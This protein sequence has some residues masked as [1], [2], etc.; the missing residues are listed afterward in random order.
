MRT[1]KI[2][3]KANTN[4]NNISKLSG[5]LE[6]FKEALFEKEFEEKIDIKTLKRVV[7]AFVKY[8]KFSS[9]GTYEEFIE[10]REK[11]FQKA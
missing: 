11:I 3:E 7:S 8:N 9:V 4:L 5:I 6:Y 10:N 2:Q 1:D